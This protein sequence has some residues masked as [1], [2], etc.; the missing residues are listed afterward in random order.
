MS[1]EVLVPAEHARHSEEGIGQKVVVAIALAATLL[2]PAAAHAAGG[3]IKG[4][5]S[6]TGPEPGNRVIRMGMD[7]MCAAVNRGK[8]VVN[9]IYEVGDKNALGNVFVKVEGTFPA[10]PVPATPVEIDQSACVYRPRVVGARVGQV[11]RVKNSDN[12]LH[13]VHSDSSR[14]NSVNQSTPQANMD[15]K[16]TLKDEEMLRLGCDVHRWMTAWVGVVSHPYFAVSEGKGGTFT[17]ANVPAG[18]RTI[19]AWH[20]ALGALTKAV[21]VKDGQTVT[22]DF[23]YTQK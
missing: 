14:R 5:I 17:I 8:Q 10:T 3:T 9:E 2:A 21:E 20:E 19:T 7:P 13:N 1:P 4:R 16:L 11:L 6:F 22:V 15:V 23:V 12:W 18:K